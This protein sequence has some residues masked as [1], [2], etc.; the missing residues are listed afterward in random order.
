MLHCSQSELSSQEAITA[1]ACHVAAL[2]NHQAAAQPDTSS[3][4]LPMGN[5]HQTSTADSLA[6]DVQHAD[7]QQP[8]AAEDDAASAAASSVRQSEGAARRY[9]GHAFAHLRPHASVPE[10]ALAHALQACVEL[11]GTRKGREGRAEQRLHA[12]LSC[13]PRQ[14][15]PAGLLLLLGGLLPDQSMTASAVHLQPWQASAWGILQTVH[16]A[17][18]VGDTW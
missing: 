2:F 15:R 1:A 5:N 7:G 4:A 17:R 14:P 3:S 10:A 8:G 13:W 16:A 12:A 11:H 6:N 18:S 9:L